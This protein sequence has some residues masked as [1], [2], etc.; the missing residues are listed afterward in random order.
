MTTGSVSAHRAPP[1]VRTIGEVLGMLWTGMLDWLLG[2][3]DH[4]PDE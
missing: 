1:L 3:D 2:S 4:E